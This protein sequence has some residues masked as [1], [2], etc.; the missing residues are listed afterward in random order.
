M[1]AIDNTSRYRG[2]D[3]FNVENIFFKPIQKIKEVC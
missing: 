2:A 1:V 3:L